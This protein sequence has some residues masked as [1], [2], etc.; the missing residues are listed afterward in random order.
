MNT[1][2]FLQNIPSNVANLYGDAVKQLNTAPATPKEPS[3]KS[4]AQTK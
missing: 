2:G 1:F 3:A 4:T